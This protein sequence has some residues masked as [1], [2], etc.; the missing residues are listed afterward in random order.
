M[1]QSHQKWTTPEIQL[2]TQKKKV[3]YLLDIMFYYLS[4]GQTELPS[5]LVENDQFNSLLAEAEKLVGIGPH[6]LLLM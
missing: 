4:T 2:G 1:Q 6:F 3:A 5:W